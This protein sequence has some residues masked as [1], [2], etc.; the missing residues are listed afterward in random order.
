MK[1]YRVPDLE[2]D[3]GLFVE[4]DSFSEK[5][6]ACGNLIIVGEDISDVLHE[7]GGLANAF[8]IQEIPEEPMSRILNT[9]GASFDIAIIIDEYLHNQLRKLI[10][11]SS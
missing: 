6:D 8:V 4:L 11:N 2:F 9:I 3:V 10:I 5:L 7:E 1:M